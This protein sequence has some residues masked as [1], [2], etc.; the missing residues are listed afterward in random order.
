M[1][2]P[3]DDM[4]RSILVPLDGSDSA[5]HA[6]PTALCLARRH[7]AALHVARV[8]VPV[9]G[10]CGEHAVRYDEALD[11]ALMERARD[12]LDG[13]AVRLAAVAGVRSSSALLEGPIADAIST[14]A[15][16]VGAD[17]LVMTTQGRGPLA[18]FLLGSVSDELVRQAGVPILL[19]RPRAASPPDLAQEP[20]L[21]R[22]LVPLDG[23]ALAES[24]LQPVLALGDPV[25][26]EYT[27]LRIVM[28]STAELSYGPAGGKVTGLQESLER[29]RELDEL[30]AKRAHEYLE[31]LA[32]RLRALV[33][34]EHAC[35]L[36]RLAGRRHPRRRRCS[37]RRPHRLGDPWPG[38]AA[39][40]VARER[41]G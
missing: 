39:A 3:E 27:L 24:I 32:G 15:T 16:A 4:C 33:R 25:Q 12:Y 26:T 30:G 35:D 14:H 10:V 18:R 2:S 1:Q 13:V 7:R 41:G 31:P 17:L 37:R 20:P 19:V 28:V 34:R 6:L 40:A 23:S 11:R 5:E 36:E 9:A 38:R 22:V 8:Y 21:R 29:L